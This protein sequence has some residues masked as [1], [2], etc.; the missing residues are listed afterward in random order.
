MQ[1]ADKNTAPATERAGKFLVFQLDQEEFG[2]RV[3]KVREI[4]GIQ[5]ITPVPHCPAHIKGVINLRGK[6]IP[7]IDLRLRFGLAPL[8]Y[9]AR[10]CIVVVQI[11]EGAEAMLMGVVVDGVAEVLNVA[12]ADVE[13]APEFGG[14][15]DTSYLL[16][17]AK[18]KG[19][20][21]L[22]LDIDKAISVN[23]ISSLHSL[24]EGAGAM[25]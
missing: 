16:G 11:G 20:V 18:V 2:I 17:I 21:K 3:L 12:E 10:T 25:A 19:K 4:M 22:L 6:I 1:A 15:V 7:V 8:E 23:D 24:V 5:A 14:E 13:K 9:S